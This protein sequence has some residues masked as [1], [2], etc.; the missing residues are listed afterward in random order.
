MEG[1]QSK[2]EETFDEL[3]VLLPGFTKHGISE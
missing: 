3:I 1:E 2:S